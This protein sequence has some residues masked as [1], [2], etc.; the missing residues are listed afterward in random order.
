VAGLS[1]AQIEQD[2]VGAGGPPNLA[3]LMGAIAMGESGGDPNALNPTDNGGKQSSFGLWQISNGTHT[4]PAS[5][6]ND[7]Q[8]NA[9]LAVAK[10]Q[11]QGLGA[12]GV[13]T[14]GAWKQYYADALSAA[15][16]LMLGQQTPASASTPGSTAN[17]APSQPAGGSTGS[18]GGS[19]GG[20]ANWF[21]PATW[22]AA[23][24]DWWTNHPAGLVVGGLVLLAIAF[25]LVMS[26]TTQTIVQTAPAVAKGA[27]AAAV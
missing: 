4:A 11:S 20:R 25:A 1:L 26:G 19:S 2:W 22:N 23:W 18:S 14:S 9:N 3:A 16:S 17:P 8:V 7:P 12:W 10:F 27:A 24:G 5:N 15:S 13:Y 6:W 21:D